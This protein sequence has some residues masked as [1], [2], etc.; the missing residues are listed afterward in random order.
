MRCF[1]RIISVGLTIMSVVAISCTTALAFEH[2]AWSGVD[3]NGNALIQVQNPDGTWEA[4]PTWQEAYAALDYESAPD[5]I[6]EVIL[7]ARRCLTLE[8]MGISPYVLYS[9]YLPD[10]HNPDLSD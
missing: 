2:P 3:E 6:K 10:L 7:I 5:D 4:L 9:E 1:N 8:K